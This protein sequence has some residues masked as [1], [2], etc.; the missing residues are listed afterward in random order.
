M[1]VSRIPTRQKRLDSSTN[2]DCLLI[3]KNL[4]TNNVDL[5]CKYVK[6]DCINCLALFAR[7]AHAS[8]AARVHTHH[9]HHTQCTQEHV[10]QH[11]QLWTCSKGE[12]V[13][14]DR[15]AWFVA[16]SRS[17]LLLIHSSSIHPFIHSSIH[18]V[19][20]LIHPSSSTIKKMKENSSTLKSSFTTVSNNILIAEFSPLAL[21]YKAVNLGQ[22]FPDFNGPDFV[23]Q[24]HKDAISGGASMNQYTRSG[25]HPRLVQVCERGANER[26]RARRARRA[27]GERS[28]D[29]I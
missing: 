17:S 23:L 29:A 7:I 26:E 28:C 2:L 13:H 12:I 14:C 15:M 16:L 22:G 18:L 20:A 8:S 24:A 5:I 21:K 25:G 6:E 1:V 10:K 11:I 27:R 4:P 3:C 9:T 19:Y